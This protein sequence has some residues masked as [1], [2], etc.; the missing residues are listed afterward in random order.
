MLLLHRLFDMLGL[1]GSRKKRER[2]DIADF[3]M[4]SQEDLWV[5][6]DM[7]SGLVVV[8]CPV[9]QRS[10]L[11]CATPMPGMDLQATSEFLVSM[12]VAQDRAAFICRESPC[13]APGVTPIFINVPQSLMRVP[14]P[15][16][17]SLRV[18]AYMKQEIVRDPVHAHLQDAFDRLVAHIKAVEYR[19]CEV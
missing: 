4:I 13:C 16:H 7:L 6:F 19:S 2:G 11:T 9:A 5:V 8:A 10:G 3:A 1:L 18:I 17:R 14:D 15:V 12:G